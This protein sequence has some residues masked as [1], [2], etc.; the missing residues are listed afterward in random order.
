[1]GLKILRKYLFNTKGKFLFYTF[2]VDPDDDD[3][4]NKIEKV[5]C[6]HELQHALRLCGLTELANEFNVE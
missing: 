2:S 1:M 4:I 3:L 6:V 5:I